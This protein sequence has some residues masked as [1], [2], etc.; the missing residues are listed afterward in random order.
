MADIM[1]TRNTDK[2]RQEVAAHVAADAAAATRAA[3]KAHAAVRLRQRDLLLR[4]I[5]EA[6]VVEAR[7]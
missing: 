2:L 6:P 4:L 5:S 7:Q 3:A 1:L